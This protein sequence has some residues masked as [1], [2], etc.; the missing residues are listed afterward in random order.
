MKVHF[1]TRPCRRWVDVG[2]VL[3]SSLD[4][5]NTS[6]V[7]CE[8]QHI[9]QNDSS[10]LPWKIYP[11]MQSGI[12]STF[13]YLYDFNLLLIISIS[14][15]LKKK[16]RR[17]LAVQ[18]RD[19]PGKIQEIRGRPLGWWSCHLHPLPLWRSEAPLSDCA[20]DQRPGPGVSRKPR[21]YQMNIR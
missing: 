18:N 15:K 17:F 13:I 1:W 5:S 19:S 7:D 4:L 21:M 9:F 11:K 3:A 16:K 14:K 8:S 20:W 10:R 6:T 2:S 12:M